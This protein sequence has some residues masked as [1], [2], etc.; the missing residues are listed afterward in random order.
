MKQ[1]PILLWGLLLP[2]S[3]LQ[4][5][6]VQGEITDSKQLPI[7]GATVVGL[8]A[9]DSSFV[10]HCHQRTRSLHPTPAA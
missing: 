6:A 2:F 9:K 5:Q 7:E 3:I 4:A 8:D 1:I 10:R